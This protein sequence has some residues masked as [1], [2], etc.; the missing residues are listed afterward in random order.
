MELKG[1]A[2]AVI[3]FVV[4]GILIGF[5]MPTAIDGINDFIDDSE[6]YSVV[7]EN[8]YSWSNKSI[9]Y[10]D[11]CS[12]DYYL[13]NNWT[14]NNETTYSVYPSFYNYT[15]TNSTYF[16]VWNSTDEAYIEWT[17]N[18]LSIGDTYY[19]NISNINDNG[20]CNVTITI[21]NMTYNAGTNQHTVY[22]DAT[23][24]I[25]TDNVYDDSILDVLP[26]M[27]LLIMTGILIALIAVLIKVVV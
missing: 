9:D 24:T 19:A 5:L 12:A 25:G 1:I 21:N 3:A 16:Y 7:N 23:Q 14:D 17:N 6:T 2:T 18:S 13:F 22:F 20:Y 8:D 11:T 27:P 4:V 26:L 15:A 10:N